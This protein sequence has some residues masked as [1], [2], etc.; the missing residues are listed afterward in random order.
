MFATRAAGLHLKL[1]HVAAREGCTDEERLRRATERTH[2][3]LASFK[4][5]PVHRRLFHRGPA[6]EGGGP[7]RHGQQPGVDAVRVYDPSASSAARNLT[8]GDA[9][10]AAGIGSVTE[11]GRG[12]RAGE[13]FVHVVYSAF[14]EIAGD[15]SS[16][17][18]TLAFGSVAASDLTGGNLFGASGMIGLGRGPLSLVSQLGETNFCYCLTPFFGNVTN[19]SHLL[20]VVGASAVGSPVTAVPFVKKPKECPFSTYY[21]LPLAGIS[22]GKVQLA[23]PAAAFDVKEVKPAG[24]VGGHGGRHRRAVHEPRRRRIPAAEGASLVPPPKTIIGKRLELCVAQADL[25][26]L[27]PPLVLHFGGAGGDVVLA[28]ENYWAPVCG[29]RRRAWWCSARRA[30]SRRR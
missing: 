30:R 14:Q 20:L 11:C 17:K 21:Y 3:R 8:C 26:R 9:A 18:V 6:A 19:P 2:R 23:V 24:E 27:V 15:L 28:P 5:E 4:P 22:V 16:D 1:T 10:C 29:M 13:C 25:A 12:A 7:P